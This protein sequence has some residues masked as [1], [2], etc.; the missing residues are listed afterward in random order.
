MQRIFILSVFVAVLGWAATATAL[1]LTGLQAWY[2]F[3]NNFN[4]TTSNGY[5]ATLTNGSVTFASNTATSSATDQAGLWPTDNTAIDMLTVNNSGA[6]G[7]VNGSG[8]SGAFGLTVSFWANFKNAVPLGHGSK[9]W[10]VDKIDNT[11]KYGWC[12]YFERGSESSPTN[13][14]IFGFYDTDGNYKTNVV[15]DNP[16]TGVPVYDVWRHWTL[17]Y[18][19]NG[20]NN[21][22]AKWYEREVDGTALLDGDVFQ[23]ND[24][25]RTNSVNVTI[26]DELYSNSIGRNMCGNI[27]EL[28]I[29]GRALSAAEVQE[30][31]DFVRVPEPG[32]LAL[33]LLGLTAIL[34][35][36]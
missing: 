22:W 7:N 10:I 20:P 26:G 2:Q 31:Y 9:Y 1:P 32:T 5:H 36:R 14:M 30:V 33:V 35:R 23:T 12:L 19:S 4:D 24:R 3:E 6:L 13:R 16:K 27:D 29:W 18:Q 17:V 15:S 28:M 21:E 34:R 25:M 11:N 8:G